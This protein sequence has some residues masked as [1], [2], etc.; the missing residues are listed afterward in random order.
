M[1]KR[2]ARRTLTQMTDYLGNAVGVKIWLSSVTAEDPQKNEHW[3]MENQIS[4][5]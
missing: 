2:E 1:N 3:S 5:Q 4:A